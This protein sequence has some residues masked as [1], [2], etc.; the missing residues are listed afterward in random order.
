MKKQNKK[1][2]TFIITC[3]VLATLI[4]CLS[5][6]AYADG[7]ASVSL[8]IE[9]DTSC[10][11][12]SAEEIV[13]GSSLKS[14][15]TS[16]NEK[17]A[18]GMVGLET[19]YITSVK[20]ISS[21]KYGGWDGWLYLINGTVPSESISDCKLNEGDEIVLFFGD[22]Y[23]VGFQFPEIEIT[24]DGI[25]FYSMDTEYDAS[26]NPIVKKKSVVSAS[27]SIFD[28]NGKEHKYI[29]DENGRINADASLLKA[30]TYSYS[31]E[32]YAANGLPL[33][34][35]SE[36]GASYTVEESP[37]T[38]D[39]FVFFAVLALLSGAISTISFRKRISF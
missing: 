28:A 24:D 10:I 36:A 3:V 2:I 11:Y 23:G 21:A 14:L 12:Y 37:D 39:E 1:C 20:G 25:S 13:P 35:R 38:S 18:L 29:T 17:A 7:K 5:S 26:F 34:L 22:P 30:G 4:S 15:L 19:D 33:V 27:V 9:G 31:I 6:G 16:V 8:R 32:K